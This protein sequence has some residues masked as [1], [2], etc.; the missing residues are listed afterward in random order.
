MKQ[1]F[2]PNTPLTR[3]SVANGSVRGSSNTANFPFLP[4]EVRNSLRKL[5]ESFFH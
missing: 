3:F 4:M 1:T 5:Q 2:I